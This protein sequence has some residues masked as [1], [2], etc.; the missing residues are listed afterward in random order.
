MALTIGIIGSGGMAHASINTYSRLKEVRVIGIAGVDEEQVRTLAHNTGI[1]NACTDPYKLLDDPQI[2]II[3][4]ASPTHTHHEYVIAAA[5]KGKHVFCEKPI[6]M[7]VEQGLEMTECCRSNGVTFMVGHLLRFFPEY[8]RAR[9]LVLQNEIGIPALAKVSRNNFIN[10][11]DWRLSMEMGGGA[12][13]DLGLHDIDWL[14]WTFG[15]VE[16]VYALGFTDVSD[17]DYVLATLRF[18]NGMMAQVEADY[19]QPVRTFRYAFELVGSGGVVEFDSDHSHPVKVLHDS[20]VGGIHA[21]MAMA[22]SD[23]LY[24]EQKHFIDCVITGAPPLV[25]GL[26]AT[27]SLQVALAARKSIELKQPIVIEPIGGDFS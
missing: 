10:P 14:R 2:D 27:K 26:D 3:H 15:E 12:I 6:S 4:I 21:P 1:T 25:S 16:R 19:A 5:N 18:K 11:G 20:S 13:V 9:S 24:T 17:K 8:A 23:P 7:T 22:D